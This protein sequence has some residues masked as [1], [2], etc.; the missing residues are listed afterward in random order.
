MTLTYA[1]A[2]QLLGFPPDS[3]G[4]LP[5]VDVIRRAFRRQALLWH[6]DKHACSNTFSSHATSAPH[7]H[8]VTNDLE[9]DRPIPPLQNTRPLHGRVHDSGPGTADTVSVLATALPECLLDPTYRTQAQVEE[10][11]KQLASAYQVLLQAA[12]SSPD[13]TAD[14]DSYFKAG[15]SGSA[16]PGKSEEE[17]LLDELSAELV[18]LEAYKLRLSD[19]DMVFLH[20]HASGAST[21]V[22]H[23]WPEAARSL[24]DVWRRIRRR[25]ERRRKKREGAG[26]GHG[27][28]DS[29]FSSRAELAVR[30][31][32]D[33]L[34]EFLADSLAASWKPQRR[35]ESHL[36]GRSPVDGAIGL[37]LNGRS[38][39]NGDSEGY[40]QQQQQ[41][42]SAATSGCVLAS[43]SAYAAAPISAAASAMPYRQRGRLPAGFYWRWLKRLVA[44]RLLF[45]VFLKG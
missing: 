9:A 25:V 37:E 34:S 30:A 14:G 40:P 42:D 38:P 5:P 35:A 16:V 29:G 24:D 11:F 18:L 31:K 3:Q 19:F 26:G 13:V 21:A 32:W 10:H 20:Q 4:S 8:C 45:F 7:S 36:S 41:Q 1:E 15:G 22:W 2:L 23:V 27:R 44:A 17:K 33:L 6:P 12:A 39:G 43:A 28:D